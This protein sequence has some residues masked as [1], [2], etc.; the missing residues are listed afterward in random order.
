MQYAQDWCLPGSEA[1]WLPRVTSGG[2]RGHGEGGNT[3]LKD[4]STFGLMAE[5]RAR[6]HVYTVLPHAVRK[7]TALGNDFQGHLLD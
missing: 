1:L 4:R 3:D 2:W 7:V 6:R 5:A